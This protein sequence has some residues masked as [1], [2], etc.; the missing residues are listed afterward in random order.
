MDIILDAPHDPRQASK[1]P[2]DPQHM[3]QISI[4]IYLQWLDRRRADVVHR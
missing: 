4:L 2:P 1:D 3:V